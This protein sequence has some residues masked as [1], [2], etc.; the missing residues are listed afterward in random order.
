MKI[1]VL[2]KLEMEGILKCC[3][4]FILVFQ[5]VDHIDALTG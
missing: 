5:L 3:V 2:L 4:F 1:D